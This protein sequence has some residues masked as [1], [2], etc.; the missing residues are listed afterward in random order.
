MEGCDSPPFFFLDLF[1]KKKIDVKDCDYIL[2]NIFLPKML[3]DDN[4]KDGNN[5]FLTWSL[6]NS[7]NHVRKQ[8]QWTEVHNDESNMHLLI[9]TTTK[10][11]LVH[12][13]F[14]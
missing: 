5:S 10:C 11:V 2:L 9:Y 13:G 7:F 4:Y 12:S 14:H 1:V 3:L 8:Q 6:D